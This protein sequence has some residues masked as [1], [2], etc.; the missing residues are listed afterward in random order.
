MLSRLLGRL[1]SKRPTVLG[2][3]AFHEVGAV[4]WPVV[5]EQAMRFALVQPATLDKN[6]D[7]VVGVA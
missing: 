7:Q 6:V 4:V 1:L 3:V 5:D 2:K